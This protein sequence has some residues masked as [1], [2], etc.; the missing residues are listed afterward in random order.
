MIRKTVKTAYLF[1]TNLIFYNDFYQYYIL[2]CY[3]F[4]VYMY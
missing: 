2:E 1:W 4:V 3:L